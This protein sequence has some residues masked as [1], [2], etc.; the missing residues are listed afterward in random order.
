MRLVV[1]WLWGMFLFPDVYV[2]GS[3]LEPGKR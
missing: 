3:L 2:C 1:G